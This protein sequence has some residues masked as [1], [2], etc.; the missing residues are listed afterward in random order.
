MQFQK[1]TFKK[2]C[3]RK[4]LLNAHMGFMYFAAKFVSMQLTSRIVQCFCGRIHPCF[5]IEDLVTIQGD[6]NEQMIKDGSFLP[7][8]YIDNSARLKVIPLES[9]VG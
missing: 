8:L 4:V 7:T 9:S 6:P 2:I 5:G 3:L 1:I